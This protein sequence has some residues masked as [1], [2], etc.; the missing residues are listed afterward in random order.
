MIIYLSVHD[1]N[2]GKDLS[3]FAHNLNSKIRFYKNYPDLESIENGSDEL[4]NTF[5]K[6]REHDRFLEELS[7]NHDEPL[8]SE[9]DMK[10]IEIL[11]ALFEDFVRSRYEN[12]DLQLVTYL[13]GNFE[14][15]IVPYFKDE[16]SNGEDYYYVTSNNLFINV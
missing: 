12:T 6:M 13:I 9:S 5:K 8:S 11:K 10:L 1:N 16:S 2:F 3:L 14:A 7:P 15:K 4:A